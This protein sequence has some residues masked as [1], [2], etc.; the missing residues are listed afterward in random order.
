MNQVFP[1]YAGCLLFSEPFFDKWG[2]GKT[3]IDGKHYLG[4]RSYEQLRELVQM[5][6]K[7]PEIIADI[8]DRGRDECRDRFSMNPA[9]NRW[10]LEKNLESA[11]GVLSQE[12]AWMECESQKQAVLAYRDQS[13]ATRMSETL[14]LCMLQELDIK[15]LPAI[16][17]REGFS[18]F[19]CQTVGSCSSQA[20]VD[21]IYTS[22]LAA[23]GQDGVVFWA[24][25]PKLQEWID[26]TISTSIRHLFLDLSTNSRLGEE[27]SHAVELLPRV[28]AN[29]RLRHVHK[30]KRNDLG[31][32]DYG[33]TW[34]LPSGTSAYLY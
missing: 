13:L 8:A 2:Y 29:R 32:D 10:L 7:K 17:I 34:I 15:E 30:V 23:T 24:R 5:V 28:E 26:I 16:V 25:P 14:L 1:M 11:I 18:D 33:Y 27:L 9:S 6:N 20:S 21:Q 4:F 22:R 19:F 3:L 31:L 12:T